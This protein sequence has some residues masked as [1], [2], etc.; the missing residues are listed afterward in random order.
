ML[1]IYLKYLQRRSLRSSRVGSQS[2]VSSRN[3][4]FSLQNVTWE[5]SKTNLFGITELWLTMLGSRL[6]ISFYV[7]LN[8]ASPMAL[9]FKRHYPSP[10]YY[11]DFNAPSFSFPKPLSPRKRRAR[12]CIDA[13]APKSSDSAAGSTDDLFLFPSLPIYSRIFLSRPSLLSHD[14]QR[15]KLWLRWQK[16]I[17][18]KF[19]IKQVYTSSYPLSHLF[20][21][22][23]PKYGSSLRNI[24]WTDWCVVSILCVSELCTP[25]LCLQSLLR[26]TS[27]RLWHWIFV[28]SM[29]QYSHVVPECW[30]AH[31]SGF[32]QFSHR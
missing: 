21:W 6:I 8:L 4:Q 3:S 1:R 29:C 20:W 28:L 13:Y 17:V 31:N 9:S 5:A 16:Q 15:G 22:Q 14:D 18:I 27:S 26:H 32:S 11:I 7:Y 19:L 23:S 24:Q 30:I 2:S 12:M 10:F 25:C